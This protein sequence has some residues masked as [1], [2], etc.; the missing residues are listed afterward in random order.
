MIPILTIV[1]LGHARPLCILAA[2][3]VKLRPLHITFF[4][5]LSLYDRVKAEIARDFASSDDEPLSRIQ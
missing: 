5:S 1:S 4:V 2:R 3:L